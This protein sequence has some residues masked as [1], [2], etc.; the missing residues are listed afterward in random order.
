VFAG[1]AVSQTDTRVLGLLARNRKLRALLQSWLDIA[2]DG[3]F[4]NEFTRSNCEATCEEI[5]GMRC[6]ACETEAFLAVKP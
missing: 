4:G 3:A 5:P 6:I 2:R 1:E